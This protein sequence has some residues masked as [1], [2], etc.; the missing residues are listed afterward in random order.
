[1]VEPSTLGI[2]QSLLVME[3]ARIR[4]ELVDEGVHAHRIGVEVVD[5]GAPAHLS[6]LICLL[7]LTQL[8]NLECILESVEELHR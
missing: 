8:E 4:V 7:G 1:M 2:S 5:K 6:N 3:F